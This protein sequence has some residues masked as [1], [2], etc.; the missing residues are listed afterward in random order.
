MAALAPAMAVLLAM[1]LLPAGLAVLYD[2]GGGRPV[3]RAVVL[4]TAAAAVQP[5]AA[6]WR[7]GDSLQACSVLL[8]DVRV[9]GMVWSAAAV[10]WLLAELIPLAAR[11]VLETTSRA[12][13][14]RLRSERN[15][16]VQDWGVDGD[17]GEGRQ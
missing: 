9:I 11:A 14:L 5:A 16:L 12:R 7:A 4:F 6:L 8:G 3:A 13:S 15:G 2:R 17:A 1:L 10:G